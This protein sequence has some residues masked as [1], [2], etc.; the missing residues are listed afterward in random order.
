MISE[1]GEACI[2]CVCAH[3]LRPHVLLRGKAVWNQRLV[4]FVKWTLCRMSVAFRNNRIFQTHIC[5]CAQ[6]VISIWS[7]RLAVYQ[8]WAES[9]TGPHNSLSRKPTR[10]HIKFVIGNSHAANRPSLFSK[11]QENSYVAWQLPMSDCH[12]RS[13]LTA[14]KLWEVL[15]QTC[16]LSSGLFLQVSQ[17]TLPT[18]F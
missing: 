6:V 12:I 16:F 11:L 15:V 13:L 17:F 1:L 8:V 5:D 18:Y 9:Y 7:A 3:V 10:I 2:D 4:T 14:L